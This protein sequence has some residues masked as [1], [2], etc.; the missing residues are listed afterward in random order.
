M[1]P[2]KTISHGGTSRPTSKDHHGMNSLRQQQRNLPSIKTGL[3]NVHCFVPSQIITI[4]TNG[5]VYVCGCPVFLPF[6]VANILD[7]ESFEE[8]RE[9]PMVKKIID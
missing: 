9:L 1:I 7:V 2:V 5:V 4:S 3:E 8:V 6:P